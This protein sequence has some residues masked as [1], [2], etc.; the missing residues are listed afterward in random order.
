MLGETDMNG[1]I[2]TSQ[3]YAFPLIAISMAFFGGASVVNACEGD[4]Y[5]R[6]LLIIDASLKL[7]WECGWSG[8]CDLHRM[9]ELGQEA[10]KLPASCQ[11]LLNQIA[12]ALQQYNTGSETY[13]HSGVCCG[14]S[15]CL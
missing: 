14:P 2:F 1:K 15:G 7:G 8:N 9:I 11:L 3:R 10:Q 6:T 5:D 12:A 13:C 4:D